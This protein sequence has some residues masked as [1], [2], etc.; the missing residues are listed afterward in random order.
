[1]GP[2]SRAFLLF[3]VGRLKFVLRGLVNIPGQMVGTDPRGRGRAC[4]S[5]SSTAWHSEWF[6]SAPSLHPEPNAVLVD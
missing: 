5:A 1:M 4:P 6:A 2:P 3:G